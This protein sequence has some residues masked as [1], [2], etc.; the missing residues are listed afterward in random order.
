MFKLYDKFDK[1]EIP[2]LILRN[3]LANELFVRTHYSDVEMSAGNLQAQAAIKSSYSDKV[4]RDMMTEIM[5]EYDADN[6]KALDFQEFQIIV[7]ESDVEMLFN[8]YGTR[9]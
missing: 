7:S 5:Q 4:I 9:S 3:I 6:N 1:G 2:I 8:L